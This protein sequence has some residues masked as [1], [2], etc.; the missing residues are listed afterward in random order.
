MKVSELIAA[1]QKLDPELTV[2]RGDSDF[3]AARLNGV[4]THYFFDDPGEMNIQRAA[5]PATG[6]WPEGGARQLMALVI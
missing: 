4:H 1:L 3:D 2:V 5:D 6:K